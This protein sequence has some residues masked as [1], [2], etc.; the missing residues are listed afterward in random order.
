MS[1]DAR[2]GRVP[3]N[4]STSGSDHHEGVGEVRRRRTYVSAAASILFDLYF[5]TD[6]GSTR[7]LITQ[8]ALVTI[9]DHVSGDMVFTATPPSVGPAAVPFIETIASG[10]APKVCGATVT[11]HF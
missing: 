9:N 10:A 1:D 2:Y 7:T 6:P 8:V 4:R 11:Y 3:P 5:V